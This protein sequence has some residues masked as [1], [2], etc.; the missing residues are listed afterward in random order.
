MSEN[1]TLVIS[2]PEILWL[3]VTHH[4]DSNVTGSLSRL[5]CPW[6]FPG[7]NT[8]VGCH[9]LLQGSNPGPL[10]CRR[11][12]Y[13]LSHQGRPIAHRYLA[14]TLELPVLDKSSLSVGFRLPEVWIVLLSRA[15]LAPAWPPARLGCLRC[16]RAPN[17]LLPLPSQVGG[18]T[19]AP[20]AYSPAPQ[21]PRL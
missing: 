13:H 14:C 19:P 1:S 17:T 20:S 4:L 15:L 7:Q 2:A 12:L 18:R 16:P 10:P 11:I 8:G 21:E 3:F 5:L 6:D 9:T